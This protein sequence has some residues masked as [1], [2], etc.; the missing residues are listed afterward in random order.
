M[1]RTLKKLILPLILAL[2]LVPTNVTAENEI[3]P[4]DCIPFPADCKKAEVAATA[5]YAVDVPDP[6]SYNWSSSAEALHVTEDGVFSLFMGK[7]TLTGVPKDGKGETIKISLSAPTPYFSSKNIVVDSPEGEELIVDTGNGFIMV[8]TSGDDCFTYDEIS[9]RKYGLSDA[10]RIMPKKE[11]KG[12]IIYTINMSK[13]YKINITVKKSALMSEEERQALME[14]AGEN[15]K[16]V[17]AEKNVNVRADASADADKVGSIKA[18]DEVI[19]T[20]PYYTEK[21]HQILY[22][23]ELCY[24]SASYLN[25]K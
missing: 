15:A 11:G 4:K 5:L 6:Q 7:G 25:V 1:G 9:D 2:S 18:G 10:Y 20:Q 21:W 13:Q 23:G 16:I 8:G 14:K 12:A 24:V 19:V 3:D 17:I 22:D